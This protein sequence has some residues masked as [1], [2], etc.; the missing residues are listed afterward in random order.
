MS[1][2]E[3]RGWF[4]WFY[5][6]GIGVGLWIGWDGVIELDEILGFV[7]LTVLLAIV[8]CSCFEALY[9]QKQQVSKGCCGTSS[10]KLGPSV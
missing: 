6:A 10:D 2:S 5:L 1:K 9:D 7:L 4:A 3:I 8:V